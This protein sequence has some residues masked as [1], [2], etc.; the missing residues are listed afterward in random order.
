MAANQSTM[1]YGFNDTLYVNQGNIRAVDVP[2]F[3]VPLSSGNTSLIYQN[4]NGFTYTHGVYWSEFFAWMVIPKHVND[5][6]GFNI[7]L[8]LQYRGN[9]SLDAE[10]NDNYY[11]VQ[12][13]GWDQSTAGGGTVCF[14]IGDRRY[15][16]WTFGNVTLNAHLPVDLPKGQY[17]FPIKILRGIQRNN[18][19]YLGGR[20]KIPSSVMKGIPFG[21]T[22][23][24]SFYNTGG[25][26]PSAQMLEINHGSLSIDRA[27][28]NY[29][30][31]TF[32]I[33]CDV[34]T[35]V[36]LSLFSNTQPAYNN[37][38]FSVGLGNGWDSVISLDGV[39]R[40]EETLHWNTAGARTVTV[41]SRLYG[42]VG[43]ITPGI[44]SGSMTM[45]MRLP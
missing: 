38:G 5:A 43:K 23:N 8:T 6:N 21:S 32:S 36:K 24:L 25:C 7:F 15:L 22:V 13:F 29:A 33:Y 12:G 10:D 40:N 34:P 4:C 2:Q 1:F 42:E 3:E 20:Y 18:Y 45:V 16:S 37:Q 31:Q 27:N 11:L 26:R 14:P 30:S 39:E 17:N 44:L 41:G 9:W 19:D 28:N 35:S